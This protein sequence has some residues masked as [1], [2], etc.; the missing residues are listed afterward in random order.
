MPDRKVFLSSTSK[1]H[2]EYRDAVY[3]S[4]EGLD[5]YHCDRMEN[6]GA[7]DNGAAEFDSMR[8]QHRRAC[9]R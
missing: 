7:R 4:I 6:W 1:D 2:D 8:A 3:D 5:G 9:R